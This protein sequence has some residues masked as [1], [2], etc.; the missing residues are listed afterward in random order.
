MGPPPPQT[1]SRSPSP[2]LP[3]PAPSVRLA[4]SL[5]GQQPFLAGAPEEPDRQL[6]SPL[7]P[8]DRGSETRE[9][10]IENFVQAGKKL[11]GQPAK[12]TGPV[13]ANTWVYNTVESMCVALLVDPQGDAEIAA[14]QALMRKT[15]EDWIPKLLSAQ[16]P[17]GYLH[18]MY[19]I[20]GI[21][22]WSNK[23]DHEGYQAG[24]FIEAAIAHYL[25]TDGK[26]PRMLEAARRLAD[27]WVNNIGPAPKRAWYEGHQELEQALVRFGRFV[28][29]KEG[30]GQRPQVCRAGQVPARLAPERRGI[31][32][33]PSARH[34]AVRSGRPRRARRLFLFRHGRRRDGDR[35]RRLPQRRA[36]ALE[37]HRQPQVLRDRRRGQRRNLGRASARTTRCRTTP[38][39]NPAPTAAN[40][41]SSTSSR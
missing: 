16:E 14:A 10:G 30:P 36:V 34:P 39:A 40:C 11:A 13:F 2:P 7:H 17:D 12:H 20:Q 5:P 29:D 28:D 21:K 38:T 22:R 41:S 35:R 31:R 19:T 23:H 33:E 25:M 3:R 37:Q 24:Y 1:R 15:L 18:T 9:G 4:P 27:C 32:P 26:D 6:D 8:Q